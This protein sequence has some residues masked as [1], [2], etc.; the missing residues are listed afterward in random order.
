LRLVTVALFRVG[1]LFARAT[2]VFNHL[3]AGTLRIDDLRRGI[4]HYWEHFSA[5]DTNIATGLLSWEEELIARFVKP[6]DRVLL[7][8]SGPGRDFIPVVAKGY[9]VTGVEP[10][11]RAIATARQQLERRGLSAEIIEGFFEEVALQGPFDVIIFSHCCYSFI[12]QSRRRIAALRKAGDHLTEGGRIIISYM[13]EQ[14][15]HPLLMRF[16]RWAATVSGSDWRPEHGD[17]LHAVDTARPL[18][19]YEH[20]FRPGEIDAEASDAGLRVAYRH[21]FPEVPVVVLEQA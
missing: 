19:H 10:V 7:V 2:R 9:R 3:A 5:C 1:R 20:A 18:F 11:R 6:D 4:E 13:T 14:S 15:G 17:V 8:G 21:T 12:P 16:A